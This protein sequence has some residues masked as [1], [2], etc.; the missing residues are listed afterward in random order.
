MKNH[1]KWKLYEIQYLS[2]FWNRKQIEN[3][4]SEENL[5]AD[6]KPKQCIECQNCCNAQMEENGKSWRDS[7]FWEILEVSTK[8][9]EL[10]EPK[11]KKQF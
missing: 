7:W 5:E 3:D 1:L 11:R 2:Q 10:H 6:L 4:K 8:V 9:K